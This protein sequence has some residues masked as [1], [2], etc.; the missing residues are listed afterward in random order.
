MANPAAASATDPKFVMAGESFTATVTATTSA[1]ATTPNYGQETVR[2]GVLLTPSLVLP[3]GG[4]LGA[5]SNATIAG[6]SFSSGVATISNLAW[7]EVGIIT[8]A[9]SV[10]DADYLGVGDVAGTITGNVGRFYPAQ[11]AI[12]GVTFTNA[13]TASTAFTY[14][15]EDGF[16]AAFTLTAKNLAG[17]TTTNYTGAFAKLGLTAYA[18]YGFTAATLPTGASLSSS[19][20]APSGTWSNGVATVSA[21]HQISRPTAITGETSITVSAAP[22][23]GE[24]PAASTA[25]SLGSATLRLWPSA[26]AQCLRRGLLALPVTLRA[27]YWNGSA[28]VTNSDDSCTTVAAPTSGAGLTFYAEVAA[29]V[30]GN[31]LS[32]A[33]TTATVNASGK[34]ASGGAG[35]T[36]SRPGS[37]NSGYVDISI[38]LA[39]RPWLQFPWGVSAVNPT[40][41]NPSGR[42]TFGLYKSR[43][44]YSRENY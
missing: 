11:F 40:G 24:V 22:T 33:E 29:G 19:A 17:G 41:L 32:A 26:I 21:K 23:D 18:N 35:L 39:A 7:S 38:P 10:G 37:G 2:E 12:S 34:L 28:W 20:T 44:I 42:A 16:T 5:L 6:G 25:S 1:G 27:Q 30:M 3:S 4:S 31:H 14:F 36:F 43:L 8:L 13:C 15:G 9:P